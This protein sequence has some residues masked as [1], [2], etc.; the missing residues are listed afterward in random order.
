M[1]CTGKR[2]GCEWDQQRFSSM[3][4]SRRRVIS[5]WWAHVAVSSTLEG[6]GGPYHAGQVLSFAC[7]S[8]V[9][10]MLFGE[11]GLLLIITYARQDRIAPS[12]DSF[13]VPEAAL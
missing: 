1:R 7:S 11:S 6:G 2:G 4:G 9:G 10:G 5:D 3:W 12:Q 8:P 13:T